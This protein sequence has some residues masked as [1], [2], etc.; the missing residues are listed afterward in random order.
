[1]E[2]ACSIKG[3]LIAA[4]LLLRRSHIACADIADS[5]GQ[6]IGLTATLRRE[7]TREVVPGSVLKF[8]GQGGKGVEF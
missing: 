6:I 2:I 1:M 5:F 4:F 8:I 3:D 7:E